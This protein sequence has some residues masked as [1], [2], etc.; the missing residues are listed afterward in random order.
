VIFIP[1]N[2]QA[3]TM[4]CFPERGKTLSETIQV[5]E[6]LRYLKTNIAFVGVYDSFHER[7]ESANEIS[8]GLDEIIQLEGMGR[9]LMLGSFNNDVICGGVE[10]DYIDGGSGND[11]IVGRALG[12]VLVGFEGSDLISSNDDK[13]TDPDGYKD[14][15]DCGPGE[16]EAWINTSIDGDMA[17]NCEILHTG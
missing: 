7:Q 5:S 1:H 13:N 2:A 3:N 4:L 10:D 8:M 9:N 12:D 15:I 17:V 6:S 11:E 14:K 16:D